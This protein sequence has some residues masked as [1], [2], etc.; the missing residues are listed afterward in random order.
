MVVIDAQQELVDLI[1]DNWNNTNTSSVTPNIDKITN[2]SFDLQFGDSKGYILI[3]STSENE[4]VPGIGLQT[5]ADVSENLKIDIRYGGMNNLSVSVIEQRFL[6]YKAE[7]KRILYLNRV[8]PTTNYCILDLDN[9]QI[10]NLSNRTKKLFREVR[11]VSLDA[12]N[13]D[14][15]V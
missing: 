12:N 11:E 4:V 13:R 8:N 6:Q 14:M 1:K 2:V 5:K 10:T 15:T 9:K 7:L 3:Y